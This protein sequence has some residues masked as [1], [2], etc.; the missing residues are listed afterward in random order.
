MKLAHAPIAAL[1]WPAMTMN[2]TVK[3]K[4]LLQGLKV[5]EAV[6]FSFIQSGKDYIVTRIQPGK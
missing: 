2:F 3:N 4:E 6:T 1:K 5:D